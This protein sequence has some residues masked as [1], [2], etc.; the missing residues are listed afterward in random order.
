MIC[1]W[2]AGGIHSIDKSTGAATLVGVTTP[3]D[4]EL[5]I[6]S[7]EGVPI[8]GVSDFLADL[9]TFYPNPMIDQLNVELSSAITILKASIY[10]VLGRSIEVEVVNKTINVEYL[11]SG[12]YVLRL[13]TNLGVLTQKLVK[14]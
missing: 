9:I 7:I 8:L 6:M 5:T 11:R 2:L 13:E 14:D 1:I 4:V 3:L 12:I 10:D